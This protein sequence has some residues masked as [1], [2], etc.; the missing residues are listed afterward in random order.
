MDTT[1]VNISQRARE[2]WLDLMALITPPANPLHSNLLFNGI[3]TT[4]EAPER[5]YHNLSHIVSMLDEA[6]QFCFGTHHPPELL[7]SIWLH[8]IIYDTHATN[9]E[10]RSAEVAQWIA[11]ELGMSQRTFAFIEQC[12]MTTKHASKPEQDIYSC[13]I[14]D[15]DLAI[16]GKPEKEFE[17]FEI[18]IKQEYAWVPENTYRE[19]RAEILNKFLDRPK[20]YSHVFFQVRYEEQARKNLKR[21]IAKL[22]GK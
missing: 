16:L 1:H 8:D 21:T 20:I 6:P 3:K 11:K 13:L 14:A 19:K 18:A 10:E 15:L 17:A 7:L 2:H 5:A 22:T 12:I 4:Y 9:N